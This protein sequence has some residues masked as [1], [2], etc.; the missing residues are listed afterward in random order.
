MRNLKR[1]QVHFLH[2]QPHSKPSTNI[3]SLL[4]PNHY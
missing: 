4:I 3:D 1:E 2:A